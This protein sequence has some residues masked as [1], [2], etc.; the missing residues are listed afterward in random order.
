MQQR[1][2]PFFAGAF[3]ACAE[4]SAG[5]LADVSEDAAVNVEDQTVDKVGSLGGE[6]HGRSAQILGFAPAL[7]GIV[8]RIFPFPP[9]GSISQILS[10]YF[11]HPAVFYVV[12]IFHFTNYFIST[13]I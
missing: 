2:P 12:R 4:Q 13:I 10:V 6:E 3:A 11:V 1:H 5:L 8:N 7:I 9:I